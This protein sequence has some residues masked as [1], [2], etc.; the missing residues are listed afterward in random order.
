M[1]LSVLKMRVFPCGQSCVTT[2]LFAYT[3][4]HLQRDTGFTVWSFQGKLLYKHPVIMDKF[5]QFLWRPRPP[6]LLT[7]EDMQV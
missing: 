2:V 1:T 5:C 6:S 3:H 7:E 4:A